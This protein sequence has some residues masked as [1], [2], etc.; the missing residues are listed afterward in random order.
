MKLVSYRI[1]SPLGSDVRV[2]AHRDGYILDATGVIA[3]HLLQSQKGLNRGRAR[4][5]AAAY[6]GRDMVDFIRGGEATLALLREA[7]AAAESA[8]ASAEVADRGE[9]FTFR[10]ASDAV[11]LEVPLRPVSIRDGLNCYTHFKNIL[12]IKSIDKVPDLFSKRPFYYRGSHTSVSGP[13]SVVKWPVYSEKLDYELE[14]FAVIG[15]EGENIAQEE[16][17][18]YIYGYTIF[19]DLSGRSIQPE[20]SATTLGPS[21]SKCFTDGNVMGPYLVTAD[22]VGDPHHLR[23]IARINGELWS[24]NN[25][26]EM[27][28]KFPEMI[29]FISWNER[30]YPGECIASGTM[31][32]GAGIEMDRWLKPGDVIELEVEKLGLLRTQV[33][34]D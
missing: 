27:Q 2:G 30:L 17:M 7:V 28:L 9:S 6:V 18:A 11:T 26:E 5:I 33:V 19:N 13:D 34:R 8:G 31:S 24:E 3:W 32:L 29:S 20:D 23:M 14:M 22:E 21:K 10:I 12:S 15:R 25:T 16:A 1:P 4:E